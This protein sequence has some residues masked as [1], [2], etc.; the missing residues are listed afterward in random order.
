MKMHKQTVVTCTI[1][2]EK[3]TTL[4]GDIDWK[5]KQIRVGNVSK[6]LSEARQKIGGMLSL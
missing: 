3:G 6:P 1:P 2:G 4:Q 5:A